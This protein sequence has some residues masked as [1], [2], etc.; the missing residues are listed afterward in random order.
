MEV[1]RRDERQSGLVIVE[2]DDDMADLVQTW[3]FQHGLETVPIGTGA[4]RKTDMNA[5]DGTGGQYQFDTA[6][7]RPLGATSGLQYDEP[8]GWAGA[9]SKSSCIPLTRPIGT[10]C[11]MW[12]RPNQLRLLE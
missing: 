9:R 2:D 12:L 5:T 7:L 10:L 3:L 6:L 8:A 4:G 11:P 1:R